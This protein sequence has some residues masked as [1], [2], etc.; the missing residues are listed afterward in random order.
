MYLATLGHVKK[1]FENPNDLLLHLPAL[2]LSE[3]NTPVKDPVVELLKLRLQQGEPALLLLHLLLLLPM[4]LLLEWHHPGLDV[5]DGGLPLHPAEVPLGLV[6][7]LDSSHHPKGLL[8][9]PLHPW[10][11]GGEVPD[12]VL[13]VSDDDGKDGVAIAQCVHCSVFFSSRPSELS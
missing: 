12:R 6:H 4:S 5:D 9:A 10:L 13:L 11:E 1:I 3:L 2:L 7:L 8:N